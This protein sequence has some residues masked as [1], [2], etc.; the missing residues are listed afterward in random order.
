[1]E[2]IV[3]RIASVSLSVA[4]LVVA[5]S[6]ADARAQSNPWAVSFDLGTQAAASGDVHGGGLQINLSERF[7]VYGSVEF[8]WQGDAED[9]DGLAGTGLESINDESGRWFV[10]ITG[11]ITVRF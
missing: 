5:L 6:P 11:G 4:A 1:M 10:P 3:K 9:L 2:E 8:E 7:A